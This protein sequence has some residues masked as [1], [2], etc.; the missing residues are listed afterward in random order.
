MNLRNNK[1]VISIF[2]VIIMLSMMI[3]SCVFVDGSRIVI[4]KTH[5]ERAYINAVSSALAGYDK[6]LKEN[7]GLFGIRGKESIEGDVKKYIEKNLNAESID[8]IEDLFDLY[9]FNVEDNFSAVGMYNYSEEYVTERYIMEHM[10]YRAP[11]SA[12]EFLMELS[13][14]NNQLEDMD[15]KTQ[16]IKDDVELKIAIDDLYQECKNLIDVKEQET[17]KLEK[18]NGIIDNI[19]LAKYFELSLKEKL[20]L[21]FQSDVKDAHK[22]AEKEAENASDKLEEAIKKL[23]KINDELLDDEENEDE[24]SSD[25]KKDSNEKEKNKLTAQIILYE[26]KLE[27]CR[28]KASKLDKTLNDIKRKLEGI[29][30]ELKQHSKDFELLRDN[31][32]ELEN[33]C[34]KIYDS[35]S[36]IQKLINEVRK[37]YN[38]LKSKSDNINLEKDEEFKKYVKDIIDKC[39]NYILGPKDGSLEKLI[40][41]TKDQAEGN[42]GVMEELNINIGN[43]EESLGKLTKKE[44]SFTY[45]EVNAGIRIMND[46]DYD[47]LIKNKLGGSDYTSAKTDLNVLNISCTQFNDSYCFDK[48][49]NEDHK[50]IW[51]EINGE[52]KQTNITKKDGDYLKD[53]MGKK[54]ND[55]DKI[56]KRSGKSKKIAMDTLITL[57]SFDKYIKSHVENTDGNMK[58][59]DYSDEGVENLDDNLDEIMHLF[60]S[61]MQEVERIPNKFYVNEY[62]MS[63]FL[64]YMHS[65]ESEKVKVSDV[66]DSGK[67]TVLDYEIEYILNGFPSDVSN[68]TAMKAKLFMIRFIPNLIHVITDP[69]KNSLCLE[70]ALAIP[71]ANLV[72]PLVQFLIM[73][74]W[75]TA[76]TYVDLTD[77]FEG[78]EVP[79]YKTPKQWKTGIN[80]LLEK[81]SKKIDHKKKL[82]I[83]N[84]DYVD[85][86]RILLLMQRK[87]K[88]LLRTEDLIQMNLCKFTGEDYKLSEIYTHIG[89]QGD[90][91]MKYLFMTSAIMPKEVKQEDGSRH[92]IKG[93]TVNGGY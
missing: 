74:A 59:I 15:K 34:I 4:A 54:S 75:A 77:L 53:E 13:N 5:V 32:D 41:E 46:Y 25:K 3:L 91:S 45:S 44:I 8:G 49:K 12:V 20:L 83:L 93:V 16:V 7:Y 9:E 40:K 87:E 81:T 76:E 35:C 43:F 86:L 24:D 6:E 70:I 42:K 18:L 67:D 26:K 30:G 92:L 39:D 21:S 10:K 14:I 64:N 56:I 33:I 37:K 88:T 71:G 55:V 27:I 89:V 78:K 79:F 80:G 63:S 72:A 19:K 29:Q 60:D 61:F 28:R 1:G 66:K 62:A 65:L 52:R 82:D 47:S 23:N 50:K 51:K 73:A 69:K 68:L 11:A 2:L 58:N 84:F 36:N 85:Y 38:K 17:E 48:N 22:D 57:P 90:V 31:C